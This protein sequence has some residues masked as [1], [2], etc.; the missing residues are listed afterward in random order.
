VVAIWVT[1]V[2]CCV[3]NVHDKEPLTVSRLVPASVP[4][5]SVKF[6]AVESCEER[7]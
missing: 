4:P 6:V 3:P 1:P 7:Q 5:E 2:P